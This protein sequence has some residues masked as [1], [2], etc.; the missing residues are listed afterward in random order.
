MELNIIILAAGLGKRMMRPDIPKVLVELNNKPLIYYVLRT[1]LSLNPAKICIIVGHKRELL[2]DY[3][4]YEFLKEFNNFDPE[5]I[6]FAV[7]E[8]QLGTGHATMCAENCFSKNQKD[9]NILIL[10]GDVPLIK[11]QTLSDFIN[12]HNQNKADI[13]VLSAITDNPYSYGRIVRD[14]NNEFVEIVE[15]KDATEK[16]KLINE[17][18][19]GM[20][21][22]K[23]DMLFNL[24]HQTNNTNNQNEYYLTD[25]IGICKKSEGKVIATQ[26]ANFDE[27]QGI[28][29]PEQLERISVFK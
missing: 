28:N 13:S 24:L 11:A 26:A 17:I 20:Y 5:R 2:I 3:V 8:Q 29:T 27:I 1:A 9:A 19:S 6:V 18:N 14:E 7:Q 12:V 22:V 4:K 21:F 23:S 25:I 16:I 15:E 10:S